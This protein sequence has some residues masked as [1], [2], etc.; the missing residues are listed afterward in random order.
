M[1]RGK[2]RYISWR[3]SI[4]S[5]YTTSEMSNDS[6]NQSS[7]LQDRT[8]INTFWKVC[9]STSRSEFSQHFPNSVTELEL[10]CDAERLTLC[11]YR[12]AELVAAHPGW[13][14]AETA[15]C[16][17]SV[18]GWRV[19]LHICILNFTKAGDFMQGYLFSRLIEWQSPLL[20]PSKLGLEK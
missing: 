12:C 9:K 15:D 3:K 4:C 16:A 1:S 2:Y 13:R 11:K 10:L 14:K 6:L 20:S 17:A 19:L 18:R 8:Q 7:E 5:V